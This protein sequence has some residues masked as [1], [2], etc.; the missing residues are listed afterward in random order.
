[1]FLKK[2]TNLF[3]DHTG[4]D[5]GGLGLVL[6]GGN[7]LGGLRGTGGFDGVL[8]LFGSGFLGQEL[9]TT[10]GKGVRV[11]SDLD[12]QVLE[13]V[14]LLAATGDVVLLRVDLGLDFIGV[15][16]SG[17][18]GVGHDVA[19]ESVANLGGGESLFG[20]PDAV[21]LF[22]GGLGPD[23][24]ATEVST[25]SELQEVET[26]NLLEVNT[27]QVAEGT[28]DTVVLGV[29]NKRTETSN[30]TT[31][32]HLT[33]TTTELL[34]VSGLFDISVSADSLEGGDSLLGALDRFVS[35]VDDEG[36]FGDGTNG[37]TTGHDQR[38][39]SRGSES[40][41]NG[42][43]LLVGVDLFVPLSPGLGGSEH[44]TGSAHVTEGGLTGTGGTTTRNT[45]DTGDGATG[46]PR[47]GGV[48]VTG[49]LGDSVSLTGVLVHAGVHEV[50]D[51]RTD[52]S[53]EDGGHDHLFGGAF[54]L[55]DGN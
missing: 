45:G 10:H 13:T 48:L 21:E 19:R 8:L 2:T 3:R 37:V 49:N 38:R 46:T 12:T 55:L 9:T 44:A 6:L 39:E 41:G 36:E 35:A 14:L 23:D 20:A 29:D 50:N 22:E 34:G 16:Q 5:R 15:D 25:G 1:M 33:N 18:I 54:G 52:G 47:V 26:V 17:K 11:Q 53:Q 28:G 42:E 31:S 27:G 32:S 51:V 7:L 40:R 30:V 4:V 43:S 24:E